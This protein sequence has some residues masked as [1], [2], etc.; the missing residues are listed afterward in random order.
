MRDGKEICDKI[1][2]YREILKQ[3]R[4]L[5]KQKNDILRQLDR[6]TMWEDFWDEDI[7]THIDRIE[8]E[9]KRKN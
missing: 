8:R 4:Y 1:K 6:A 7:T 3:I 9:V 5:R 2:R